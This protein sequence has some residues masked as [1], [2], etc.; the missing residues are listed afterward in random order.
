M[1]ENQTFESVRVNDFSGLSDLGCSEGERMAPRDVL[2]K[3]LQTAWQFTQVYKKYFDAPVA[4]REAHCLAAQYPSMCREVRKYDLIAGRLYYIPLVGFALENVVNMD[5]KALQTDRRPE[6]V[7]TEE[8]RQVRQT[9][10]TAHSGYTFDWSSLKKLSVLTDDEDEK[11][12]IE[13][14]MAFWTK[15]ASA[16]KYMHAL[17]QDIKDGFGRVTLE[18]Q[19]ASTFFRVCCL[20]VDYDKLM[21]LGIPGMQFLIQEKRVRCGLLCRCGL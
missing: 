14:M 7:L 8:E 2:L 16:H 17:P 9:L 1:K 15:E 3:K 4:I 13:E 18:C 11:A 12:A 19:Y 20:S 10:A 6:R 5:I 21:R